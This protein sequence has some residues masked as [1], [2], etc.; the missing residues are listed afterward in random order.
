[1]KI[2]L[3]LGGLLAG[4]GLASC[5]SAPTALA[6]IKVS[7]RENTWLEVDRH[8]TGAFSGSQ[9]DEYRI[10]Y[11]RRTGSDE[12]SVLVAPIPQGGLPEF[13]RVDAN[14]I[15]MIIPNGTNPSRL[16][17][18]RVSCYFSQSWPDFQLGAVR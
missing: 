9:H 2:L 8:W 6:S 15:E 5:E 13:K 17:Q 16:N 7:N 1:M 3:L 11:I 14:T 10:R 18:I 4:S 12:E